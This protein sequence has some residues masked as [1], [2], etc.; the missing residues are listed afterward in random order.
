MCERC[1]A[2]RRAA[3][4]RRKGA[5]RRAPHDEARAKITTAIEA[6]GPGRPPLQPDGSRVQLALRLSPAEEHALEQLAPMG[7][8]SQVVRDLILAAAESEQ[9]RAAVAAWR[10]A[11]G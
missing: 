11:R 9:V 2:D 5:A 6:R 3:R 10:E 8:R 7:G 4:N 1:A